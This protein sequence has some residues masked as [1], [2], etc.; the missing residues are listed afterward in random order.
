MFYDETGGTESESVYHY[1]ADGF[2][3]QKE[4]FRA[5]ELSETTA[6]TFSEDGRLA[7]LSTCD[8]AGVPLS[9]ETYDRQGNLSSRSEYEDGVLHSLEKQEYDEDGKLCEG[10]RV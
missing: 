1:D 8:A 5:G 3:L 4:V 6:Y 7:S 9:A 2:R 10:Q